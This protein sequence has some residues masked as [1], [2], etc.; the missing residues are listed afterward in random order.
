MAHMKAYLIGGPEDMVCIPLEQK[1]DR[2][3]FTHVRSLQPA[4]LKH[5]VED[6]PIE[7]EP[8]HYRRVFTSYTHNFSIYVHDDA[9]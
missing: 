8:V 7:V 9:L 4:I 6:Y 2:L 3:D 1:V 5:K